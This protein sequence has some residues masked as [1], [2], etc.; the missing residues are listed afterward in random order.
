MVMGTFHHPKGKRGI[1]LRHRTL[2]VLGVFAT[3][4]ACQGTPEDAAE[5]DS[6]TTWDPKI[7]RVLNQNFID[8][9]LHVT[10]NGLTSLT[11]SQAQV[12]VDWDP[13]AYT[14]TWWHSTLTKQIAKHPSELRS[15]LQYTGHATMICQHPIE[16]NGLTS[17]SMSTA[18]VLSQVQTGRLSLNGLT[19]LSPVVANALI[20]KR[21]YGSLYLNGIEELTPDLAREF[22]YFGDSFVPRELSLLGVDTISN[23]TIEAL[24]PMRGVELI[25]GL[26]TV[27]SKQMELFEQI[28]HSAIQLPKLTVL[29]PALIE[30]YIE[31]HRDVHNHV[32]FDQSLKMDRAVV[33]S[34]L[35]LVQRS[36]EQYDRRSAREKR[37]VWNRPLSVSMVIPKEWSDVWA[38][39]CTVHEAFVCIEAE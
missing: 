15:L 25:L 6:L 38:D 12:L 2:S 26:E 14:Q 36:H 34:V 8:T 37:R 29:Q 35:S 23:E 32:R 7:E 5:L 31:T 17:L 28:E 24:Q 33:N 19:T 1:V 27:S 20:S 3:V 22:V 11:P 10:L 4:M 39:Q 30:T 13:H 9:E 18:E 16:L 21:N